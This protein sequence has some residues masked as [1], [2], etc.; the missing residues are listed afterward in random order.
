MSASASSASDEKGDA[1]SLQE[2]PPVQQC[3]GVNGL[4]KVILCVV[5]G[6]SAEVQSVKIIRNKLASLLED[7]GF[8]EFISHEA[9][10]SVL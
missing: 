7:Y 3:K 10:E 5:R 4:D 6:C 2:V 9:A 1:A 8:I